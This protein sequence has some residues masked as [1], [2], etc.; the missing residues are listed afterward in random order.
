ND[1]AF[2]GAGDAIPLVE[3]AKGGDAIIRSIG[4]DTGNVAPRVAG[5]VWMAGPH[6]MLDDVNFAAGHGR[7]GANFGRPQGG[8]QAGP[9]RGAGAPAQRAGGGPGG[10]RGAGAP[11]AAPGA[12]VAGAQGQRPAGGFARGPSTAETQYPSITVRDGGGGLIRGVWTSNTN[13]KAGLVVE[14]TTTP[15]IVYQMSCE[16]HMHHE[17]QF[18]HA[19]NWTIYALQTE[20]ENPAGADS[21]TAELNDAH[22]IT[23]VNLFAYRVSRNIKPKLNAVE[24]TDS[25]G[26]RFENMHTFSMTRLAYD[27]SVFDSTS[28]VR[29]RTHDFTSFEISAANKPGPALPLPTA[30][31]PGAKLEQVAS[32]FSNASGLTTDDGGHLF[33]TDSAMHKIYRWNAATKQAELLTNQVPAPQAVA[34]LAPHTLLAVDLSKAVYNV[35]T[36]SGAAAKLAPAA[37]ALDG[38]SLLLPIG[39]HNSMDTLVKQMDRR[40]VVYARGSNMAITAAVTDE[41]RDFFYAPGTNTAVMAGGTWQPMLQ[42]S[43]W[44]I[45][46]LGGKRLAVSEEDDATDHI[47]LAGLKEIGVAPFLSRGGSS[48]VTDAAGNV[49]VADG[50]LYLYSPAGKALGVVE[51]PERPTSLAFGGDDHRTLFIGARGSIFAIQTKVAGR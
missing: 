43:Q 12:G 47:T 36:E 16:H 27:N 46:P 50:Q 49:Y 31:V 20:E 34:F 9:P 51:V 3:S 24:S 45:V 32:G 40:G 23:F 26:I 14:N 22:N 15:T 37:T 33:F 19:S 35:D 18:H 39:F 29:V 8:G 30:F 28:G 38:T 42:A 44:A 1:P 10:P 5:I 11:G 17:T 2:A 48:V 7:V 25:T 4:I 6:S 13:A 21:F 41:H